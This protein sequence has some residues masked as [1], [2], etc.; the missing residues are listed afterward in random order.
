[1]ATNSWHEF[2][3]HEFVPVLATLDASHCRKVMFELLPVALKI[4]VGDQ[5]VFSFVLERWKVSRYRE[6]SD[7]AY[8]LDDAVVLAL[9][10][11]KGLRAAGLIRIV[12][13]AIIVF[14]GEKA[15]AVVSPISP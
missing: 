8:C 1:V 2:Y 12:R 4:P 9:G 10:G 14:F 11:W 5:Q 7:V 6:I 15:T 13:A 3:V